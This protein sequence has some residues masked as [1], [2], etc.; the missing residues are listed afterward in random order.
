MLYDLIKAV[1]V[2]S[3]IGGCIAVAMPK[4]LVVMSRGDIIIDQS[5]ALSWKKSR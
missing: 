1:I 5:G 3:I 4:T 2:A